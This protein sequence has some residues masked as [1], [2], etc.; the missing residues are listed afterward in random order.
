MRKYVVGGIDLWIPKECVSKKLHEVLLSG[1]YESSEAGALQR[2]LQTG[3]RLLDLGS[4]AGYLCALAAKMIGGNA[5]TGV[6]ALPRMAEAAQQNLDSNSDAP[7]RIVWGAVV[8]DTFTGDTA[9]LHTGRAFWASSL[10]GKG[11]SH[12]VSQVEVPALRIGALLAEHRPTVI[13]IDVEGGEL[14]LFD[15]A[16]PDHVRLIVMEVHPKKYG[17]SGVKR[18]FDGLSAAGLTYSPNG[19]RGSTVVFERVQE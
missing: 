2:H 19:S 17:S 12:D 5:V 9:I 6:E 3:D 7:G 13:S 8:P 4:G 10:E 15:T 1:N 14:G 11:I 18:I 16:L